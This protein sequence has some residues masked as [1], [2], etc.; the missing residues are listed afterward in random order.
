ML[1]FYEMKNRL[2]TD[3][4]ALLLVI[5]VFIFFTLSCNSSY[6][7][8]RVI[9]TKEAPAPIGPYSQA[10]AAY[11][12]IYVSGQIAIDPATNE[13]LS[14]GDIQTETHQVMK[15]LDAILQAAGSSMDKVVKCSIFLSDMN[16][17][18]AVNEVYGTYFTNE[19]PAR[20]TVEVSKLPKGVRV[21]ISA[22][23]LQ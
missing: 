23:A 4:L 2:I 21:E 5:A 7:M 6:S 22:I 18:A 8:K 9:F 10:I 1:Q 11:G 13:L 20:E 12:M 17:F 14:S 16:N 3:Y 19:P 15:N